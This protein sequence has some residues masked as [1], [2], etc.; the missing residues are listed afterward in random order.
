[1]NILF[2]GDVVGR[3]G[4][5]VVVEHLPDLRKRLALDFVIVNGENA[6][7]G[8]GITDKICADLYEAGADV[9]TTGNHV[10]DQRD[11][12]GQIDND[13][14]LLRPVNF[15]AGTPGRG[16]NVYETARGR[17][18]LVVNVMCRLFMD[19]LDDPFPALETLLRD[20]PLGAAVDAIVIDTH[21]EASSEKMA[22]GHAFDGRASLIVGTHTHVPTADAQILAGGTAYQTD[23][24][25]C[26]DYDSVIGMQKAPAIARF[27]RKMPGERLS[28]ASGQAD[29]CGVFIET[30]DSSGLARYVAPLRLGGRLTPALPLDAGE[31]PGDAAL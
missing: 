11:I 1:M 5:D 23:A 21:G 7:H 30:D 29:L 15:P 13:P 9:I 16:A 27:R 12:I 26:G 4:R 24:G 28:P 31:R 8:F 25:M 3:A 6:A 10:W 18:V 14:R 22:M 17:R 2:C 19:P 20:H